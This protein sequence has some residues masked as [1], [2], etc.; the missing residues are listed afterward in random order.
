MVGRE[1]REANPRFPVG[2]K[3]L[4]QLNTAV[5]RVQARLARWLLPRHQARARRLWFRPFP[6][7]GEHPGGSGSHTGLVHCQ[8]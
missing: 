5:A 1:T 6:L 4:I 3:G 7:K 8:G 2:T